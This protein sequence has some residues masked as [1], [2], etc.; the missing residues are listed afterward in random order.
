M[1]PFSTAPS[2]AAGLFAPVAW[3]LVAVGLA[4]AGTRRARHH[5]H[6]TTSR[7]AWVVLSAMLIAGGIAAPDTLGLNHGHYL[8]QR[9]A[10]LGLA[11]LLPVLDLDPRRWT[12][13]GC[14]GALVVALAVQS[15]LVWTYALESERTAGAFWRARALVG[16]GQRVATLLLRL[17]LPGQPRSNPLLHA[18][19]L[20]GIGTGNVIWNNYETRHYYFPVQFRAGFDRPD[21]GELEAIAFQ[22]DPRDLSARA[23]HWERLLARHHAA[24]DVLV[25]WGR[26]PR[27]DAITGR[28]FRPVAEDGLLR[29]LRHQ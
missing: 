2:R 15:A 28:W 16:H 4:L 11:A 12:V 1:L 24:I 5:D 10:L 23:E 19:C 27:L 8:P 21:A 3:L 7:R 14:A 9:I 26:E 18:D 17:K 13:R 25:V 29:I 20:L 6:V 22:D